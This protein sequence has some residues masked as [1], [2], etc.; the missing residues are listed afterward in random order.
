MHFN[1]AGSREF[2]KRYAKKMLSLL[3]Y[4]IPDPLALT[5]HTD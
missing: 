5:A 2:G 3:G 1:S 4:E